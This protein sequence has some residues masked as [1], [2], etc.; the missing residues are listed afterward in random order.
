MLPIFARLERFNTHHQISSN[1]PQDQ[2][3]IQDVF[4]L[5]FGFNYEPNEQMA[6]KIDYV[7]GDNR[8][9]AHKELIEFGL[10]VSF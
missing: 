7:I 10:G 8:Y 2:A 6:I 5:T 9:G 3:V 1:L 4:S